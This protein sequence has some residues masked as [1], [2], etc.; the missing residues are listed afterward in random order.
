MS[1]LSVFVYVVQNVW[2]NGRVWV[3]EQIGWCDKGFVGCDRE[4]FNDKT[5]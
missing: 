1:G 4:R 5:R 3:M 2:S